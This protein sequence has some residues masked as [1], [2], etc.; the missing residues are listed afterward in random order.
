[1]LWTKQWKETNFVYSFESKLD[2]G[3]NKCENS[4]PPGYNEKWQ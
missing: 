1:M 3:E 4:I 2:E